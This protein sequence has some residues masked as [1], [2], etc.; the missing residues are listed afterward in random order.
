MER[1]L[2]DME[3]GAWSIDHTL[4]VFYCTITTHYHSF[5]SHY[6]IL[7]FHFIKRAI[8]I[9][10]IHYDYMYGEILSCTFRVK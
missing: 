8:R 6:Y 7:Y 5:T 9:F 4:L 10:T 3:L 2:V 1:G